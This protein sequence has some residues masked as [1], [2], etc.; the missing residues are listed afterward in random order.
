MRIDWDEGNWPKCGKHGVSKAEIEGVLGGRPDIVEDPEHSRVEE[1]FRAVGVTSEG[2]HL[3]VVF[4]L[5]WKADEVYLR[6]I[7]ARFMHRDEVQFYE[8]AGP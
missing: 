6:P 7:S 4:T 5:R 1:R 3:F 2:R 8:K